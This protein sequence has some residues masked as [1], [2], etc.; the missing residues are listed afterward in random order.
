VLVVDEV[1][2]IGAVCFFDESRESIVNNGRDHIARTD[3][4][5]DGWVC[6][7]GLTFVK[8]PVVIFLVAIGDQADATFLVDRNGR[9][10]SGRRGNRS[11]G[12][13]RSSEEAYD[14]Y[15][16]KYNSFE[17]GHSLRV[18]STMRTSESKNRLVGPEGRRLGG[19]GAVRFR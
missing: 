14:S 7:A 9:G 8:K 15:E 10:G 3:L 17:K 11:F 13:R 5:I 12:H 4:G 19:N 2:S 18:S 1:H 16:D 6:E